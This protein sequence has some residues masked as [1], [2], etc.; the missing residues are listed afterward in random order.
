MARTLHDR[1]IRLLIYYHDSTSSLAPGSDYSHFTSGREKKLSAD[2]LHI[3]LLHVYICNSEKIVCSCCLR[4]FL[5]QKL[6]LF[7][8]QKKKVTADSMVC[9]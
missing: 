9:P 2:K 4:Q 8:A 1:S 7:R 6:C 3:G 5:E